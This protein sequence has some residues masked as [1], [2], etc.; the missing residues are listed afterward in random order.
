VVTDLL[1]ELDRILDKCQ[2]GTMATPPMSRRFV[3]AVAAEIRRLRKL[4]EH[5]EAEAELAALR[6]HHDAEPE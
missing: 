1:E 5:L 2:P 3:T 4:V 6:G